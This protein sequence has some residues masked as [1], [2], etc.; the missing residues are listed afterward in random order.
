MKN[1]AATVNGDSVFVRTTEEEFRLVNEYFE[2]NE[3]K[4]A[5]EKWL[6]EN[7]A[8]VEQIL[9]DHGK[10]KMDF[11]NVRVTVSV[12]DTSK[13]DLD[14]VLEWAMRTDCPGGN[15]R[16]SELIT[17]QVIDEDKLARYIESG[18]INIEEIKAAAWVESKGSPRLVVS[19]IRKA[20]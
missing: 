16:W 19:A 17:K 14:K 13:F 4:K 6:K 18:D 7:K 1:L 8:R 20:E 11:G 10:D 9:A 12:P 2:R 15:Y 5:D 3:R